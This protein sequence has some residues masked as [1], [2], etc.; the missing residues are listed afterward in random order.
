M[1]HVPGQLDFSIEEKEFP[2]TVFRRKISSIW[3]CVETPGHVAIITRKGKRECALI[4][5]ETYAC[6]SGDYHV[7]AEAFAGAKMTVVYIPDGVTTLGSK[8]FANCTNLTQIRIPASVT[9]IPADLL[10][11][12]NKSQLT[13]FG[14]P[15]SAAETFANGAGIKFAID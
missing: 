13:I 4:S 12:I 11:D 8:A 6:M 3:D 14:A 5:I 15:D 1:S 2:V 10:Y 7:E 9:I